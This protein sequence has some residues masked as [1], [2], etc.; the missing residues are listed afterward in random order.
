MEL[1]SAYKWRCFQDLNKRMTFQNMRAFIYFQIFGL[2]EGVKK[3]IAYSKAQIERTDG[4]EAKTQRFR[5]LGRAHMVAH[6]EGEECKDFQCR[7]RC[8]AASAARSSHP[9]RR[10]SVGRCGLRFSP[11]PVAPLAAEVISVAPRLRPSCS[12]SITGLT[13]I[14][15]ALFCVFLFF[16]SLCSL[17]WPQCI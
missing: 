10:V 2:L 9:R 1:Y 5:L 4:R 16:H 8:A 7:P 3:L 6:L 13:W 12:A 17:R 15:L 14:S 11:W